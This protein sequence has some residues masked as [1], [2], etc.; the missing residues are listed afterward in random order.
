M[1][2]SALVWVGAPRRP[3]VRPRVLPVALAL[4]WISDALF[5][6]TGPGVS[7]PLFVLLLVAALLVLGRLERVRPARRNLW[8]LAPLIFFAAMVPLRVNT[9]LTQLN[10]AATAALL[11]LVVFF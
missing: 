8:L 4:G 9:L 6:G 3:L 1:S 10:L 2:V 5:Y 7:A 11:G